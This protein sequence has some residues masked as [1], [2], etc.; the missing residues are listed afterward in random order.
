M[1]G[2]QGK[3]CVFKRSFWF[4]RQDLLG[5]GKHGEERLVAGELARRQILSSARTSWGRGR[6]QTLGPDPAGSSHSS[7]SS[8][9]FDFGQVMWALFCARGG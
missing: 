8:L 5:R 7:N 3:I 2:R 9:L 6:E 1:E 4:D